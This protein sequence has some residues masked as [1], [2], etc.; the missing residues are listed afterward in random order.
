MPINCKIVALTHL[1]TK[2][3]RVVLKAEQAFTF[4]AGQYVMVEFGDGDKLPFSIACAPTENNLFEIH[5]GGISP[6]SKLAEQASWL[7][8]C[9]E[10]GE[11]INIDVAA[12]H[13]WLRP[14]TESTVLIAGGSGYTYTRSL[15]LAILKHS[16]SCN[17]SLYWGA[18]S[19]EDLYEHHYLMELTKKHAGFRYIPIVEV[20]SGLS[21][22]RQGRLMDI[23]E[24]ECD[25]MS[26]PTTYICGRYEMVQTAFA[27][28]KSKHQ[29][30]CIYSDAL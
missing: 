1:N 11:S 27:T 19:E 10:Q 25:F 15:L 8:Q 30:L 28:L 23:V 14:P 20:A 29:A 21:P 22:F 7:R 18:F 6:Q 2:T 16:P 13:A 12:G 26:L 5:L 17:V 3:L 4:L 9:F 24:Q